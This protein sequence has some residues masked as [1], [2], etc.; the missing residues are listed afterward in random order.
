MSRRIWVGVY[1]CGKMEVFP[2]RF[3][4]NEGVGKRETVRLKTEK[5]TCL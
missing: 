2:R 4:V 5:V 1:G 3:V